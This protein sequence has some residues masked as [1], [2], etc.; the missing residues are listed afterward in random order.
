[1]FSWGAWY[2]CSFVCVCG[3]FLVF[4]SSLWRVDTTHPVEYDRDCCLLF[5]PH[6][7]FS[8][9]SIVYGGV[10]LLLLR[11]GLIDVWDGRP[12]YLRQNEGETRVVGGITR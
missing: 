7:T 4:S 2:D 10:A 1:V 12:L 3:E 6:L 11:Q 8:Q 5:L 9:M